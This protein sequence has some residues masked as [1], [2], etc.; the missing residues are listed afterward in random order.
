MSNK[1]EFDDDDEIDLKEIFRT[2]S[3]YKYFIIFCMILFGILASVLAYFKPNIYEATMTIEIGISGTIR[4]GNDIVSRAISTSL[5]VNPDT[6]IEILKSR[7]LMLEA[8][9][10][11]DLS[12][13][14]YTTYRMKKIEITEPIKSLGIYEVKV[15]VHHAVDTT[16][17]TWVVRE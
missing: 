14:Y 13:R 8:V 11:V 12:H 2:L 10:S 3:Q 9:K 7:V 6:E 16:V 15:K 5:E 17:K 4:G 1:V